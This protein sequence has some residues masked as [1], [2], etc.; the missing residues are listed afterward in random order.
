MHIV[1]PILE[2]R[3]ITSII[4]KELIRLNIEALWQCVRVREKEE[5]RLMDLNRCYRPYVS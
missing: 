1:L 3:L 4:I 2:H 5:E